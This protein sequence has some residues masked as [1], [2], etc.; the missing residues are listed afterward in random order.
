MKKQLLLIASLFVASIGYS[1]TSQYIKIETTKYKQGSVTSKLIKYEGGTLDIDTKFIT[2]DKEA[3]KPTYYKIASVGE[4]HCEDEG[5]T[6]REYICVTEGTKG[7][8]KA[9]YVVAIY[10]PKKELTDLIVKTATS[11]ID[12]CVTN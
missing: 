8:L 4:V 5:Y 7:S 2:I 10:S 3:P 9:L 12:Y 6:S 1:Q 11:H